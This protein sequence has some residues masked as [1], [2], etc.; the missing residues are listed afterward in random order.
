MDTAVWPRAGYASEDLVGTRQGQA[1][2]PPL[3][4]VAI[5]VQCKNLQFPSSMGWGCGAIGRGGTR[6]TSSPLIK[7]QSQVV[8]GGET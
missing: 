3:T 1:S 5:M 2:R 7:I 8:G 4:Q 6:L